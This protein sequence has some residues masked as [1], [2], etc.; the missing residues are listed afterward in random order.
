MVDYF[1]LLKVV[2]ELSVALTL[3]SE[4]APKLSMALHFVSLL[5]HILAFVLLPV[6]CWVCLMKEFMS[7]Q[8]S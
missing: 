8:F 5:E 1:A 3:E 2:L 6:P 7:S 4:E